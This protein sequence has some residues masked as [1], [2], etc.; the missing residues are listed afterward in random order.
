[1]L[2]NKLSL[3]NRSLFDDSFNFAKSE[4]QV[5]WTG[6]RLSASGSYI[7][8]VADPAEDRT[9][10]ASEI[11]LDAAYRLSRHWIATA[12][13]RYDVNLNRAASAGLGLTYRN[14]CLNVDLSLSRRFTSSTTLQP[15]TDVGLSV[16]LNGFGRSGLDYARS[17]QVKG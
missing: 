1:M 8:V 16:S 2:D 5:R 3:S 12:E 11:N 10:D 6:K 14:E 17:C 4:T 7:W 13:G 9:T 15:T